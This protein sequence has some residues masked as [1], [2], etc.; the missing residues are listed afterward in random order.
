[1]SWSVDLRL[2]RGSFDLQVNLEGDRRPERR[3]GGNRTRTA[4]GAGGGQAQQDQQQGRLRNPQRRP[5]D[6]SPVEIHARPDFSPAG[7][8]LPGEVRSSDIV[9]ER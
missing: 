9:N 8:A 1:M 4:G 3:G 2:R 6:C 5:S 7:F